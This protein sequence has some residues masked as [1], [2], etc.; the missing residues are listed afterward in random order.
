MAPP[1]PGVAIGATTCA[2]LVFK[3]IQL[4]IAHQVRPDRFFVMLGNPVDCFVRIFR[5]VIGLLQLCKD[6]CLQICS[7]DILKDLVII[8]DLAVLSIFQG[9]SFCL[10]SFQSLI[11][12]PLELTVGL[13][14]QGHDWSLRGVME[15][16]VV[17]IDQSLRLDLVLD[18][19][20]YTDFC[21]FDHFW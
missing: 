14:A 2:D 6:L 16:R 20:L 11:F 1:G 19:S 21:F 4:F 15:N 18:T 3:L 5:D 8:F 10:F 12:L 13:L 17:A 9:F 7:S